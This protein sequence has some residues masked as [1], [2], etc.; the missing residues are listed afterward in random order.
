MEDPELPRELHIAIAAVGARDL[1]GNRGFGT[2]FFY[3]AEQLLQQ[4]NTSTPLFRLQCQ[5]LL[6]DFAAWSNNET[7]RQWAIKEQQVV[8][9]TIRNLFDEPQSLLHSGWTKWLHTEQL[10]RTVFTFYSISISSAILLGCQI[11]LSS[12]HLGLT[13]PCSNGLWRAR[14]ELE[15]SRLLPLWDQEIEP[16]MT[17][18]N[19]VHNF[20]TGDIGFMHSDLLNI[21]LFSQHLILCAIIEAIE[22]LRRIPLNYSS[23]EGWISGAAS[24]FSSRSHF[25]QILKL[26]NNFYH[27][28]FERSWIPG[29]QA[30]PRIESV[31]LYKYVVDQLTNSDAPIDNSDIRYAADQAVDCLLCASKVGF[32]DAS[33]MSPSCHV[34]ATKLAQST[35][36]WLSR[37]DSATSGTTLDPA[38]AEIIERIREAV[39]NG[40]LSVSHPMFKPVVPPISDLKSLCARVVELWSIVL[41]N[42]QWATDTPPPL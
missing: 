35:Y 1:D 9:M 12:R 28:P 10:K 24:S 2:D 32:N 33:T 26:W 38:D 30:R 5:V 18:P 13:F 14:N 40:V 19:S 29:E 27:Q 6:I 41:G 4:P 16:T 15:W 31:M 39:A 20:L 21:S 34:I 25:L 17:F 11:P 3:E 37:L 7:L 8:A 42:M 22:S 36:R 23:I